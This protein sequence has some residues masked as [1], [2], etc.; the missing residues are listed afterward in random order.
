MR[1]RRAVV[2]AYFTTIPAPRRQGQHIDIYKNPSQGEITKTLEWGGMHALRGLLDGDDAYL[3]DADVAIHRDV[4]TALGWQ[5]KDLFHLTLYPGHLAPAI[6]VSYSLPCPPIDWRTHPFFAERP[7]L[8][9]DPRLMFW[10]SYSKMDLPRQNWTDAKETLRRQREGGE[11]GAWHD[12]RPW[13]RGAVITSAVVIGASLLST[14][15]YRLGRRSMSS[16]ELRG[17]AHQVVNNVAAQYGE[18]AQVSI[19]LNA[20][21]V[22]RHMAEFSV[23]HHGIALPRGMSLSQAY[24]RW[25]QNPVDY[26][27]ALITT[28]PGHREAAALSRVITALADLNIHHAD[29]PRRPS[30]RVRLA[31]EV[32]FT[33]DM[34]RE[35]DERGFLVVPAEIERSGLPAGI[36]PGSVEEALLRGGSGLDDEETIPSRDLRQEPWQPESSVPAMQTQGR[37]QVRLSAR[38]N[39]DMNQDPDRSLPGVPD[40]EL[41]ASTLAQAR[42]FCLAYIAEHNL[43]AGNWAGGQV[44]T[45][46]VQLARIRYNGRTF[47]RAGQEMLLQTHDPAVRLGM[48]RRPI[49]PEEGA[50]LHVVPAGIHSP[51]AWDTSIAVALAREGELLNFDGAGQ[52]WV[53]DRADHLTVAPDGSVVFRSGPFEPDVDEDPPSQDVFYLNAGSETG[54]EIWG[55]LA[56][57]IISGGADD[58][59]LARFMAETATSHVRYETDEDEDLELFDISNPLPPAPPGIHGSYAWDTSLAEALAREGEINNWTPDGDIWAYSEDDESRLQ[60]Y[61]TGAL[62]FQSGGQNWYL[63]PPYGRYIW[64]ILAE[65]QA[66]E[67]DPSARPFFR[68]LLQTNESVSGL[69]RRKHYVRNY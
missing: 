61:P 20:V 15:M 59:T 55:I 13:Q 37:Y 12:W 67:G 39:P 38:G 28:N 25:L 62:T 26:G 69:A 42:D 64:R 18:G 50:L 16:A 40:L 46:G 7:K 22:Q 56:Q 43:G 65:R 31:P 1:P 6:D 49:P 14:L 17:E 11:V 30:Q 44:S 51:S 24:L 4:I 5:A 60:V 58:G 21:P 52:I 19:D 10:E 41:V 23:A 45:D 68:R 33:A 32:E 63:S 3:W 57:R 53:S 9:S 2:G 48:P 34:V 8:F 36:D 54:Q 66:E 27:N 35:F 29:D 47:N